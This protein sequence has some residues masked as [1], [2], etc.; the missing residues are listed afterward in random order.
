[1]NP[2]G[3][4]ILGICGAAGSGKTTLARLLCNCGWRRTYFSAGLKAM[5]YSF[6]LLQGIPEKTIEK[7]LNEELKEIPTTFLGGRTPRYAMQ[8]LGTEWRNLMHQNLW[9]DAWK[10]HLVNYPAGSKIL[11]DDLRFHHEA[12]VVRDLGGKIIRLIRPYNRL[13]VGIHVSAVEALTILA[14]AEIVNDSTPEGML[15]QLA[16]V[17]EYWK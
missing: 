3:H 14:D 12:Q 16:S 13:E 9:V 15:D 5:L 2:N 11:V 10:R 1:M 4:L 7:M 6:L 8:T 17:M